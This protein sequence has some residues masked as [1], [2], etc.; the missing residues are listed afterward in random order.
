M[1]FARCHRQLFYKVLLLPVLL[2]SVLGSCAPSNVR[3]QPLAEAP[4]EQGLN[5]DLLYSLLAGEIAGNTGNLEASVKF[6][7]QAAL[8]SEDSR[9]AARATYISLYSKDYE[10][11]LAAL[12]RWDE[13]AP[14]ND[15]VNRMYAVAYLK[16]HEPELAVSYIRKILDAADYTP[17]QK[18]LAVK[19]LL[20]RESN[21]R[22]GLTVLAILNQSDPGNSKMLI[23]Q[24]R[25]AAQLEQYDDSVALLDE[26]L[27]IDDS[28][29]DVHIIKSRILAAQGHGEQA[30][31]IVRKVIADQPG[32]TALRMRFA[33]MLVEERKLD[34]AREQFLILREQTPENTDVLLSLALLHIDTKELDKAVEYLQQ[35]V[36][37]DDQVEVAYYYLGRIA[38]NREQLKLAISYY[39]KVLNGQYMFDSRL[40]VAGLL[41]RLGKNDEALKQLETL[42]EKQTSWPNQVRAYLA[43]GEILR[44]MNRFEEALDMYN[45]VLQ[46]NPDDSDLLYARAMIAEK[47]DRLD[48]TEAD[49]LKVLSTEPENANALNALGYTLADRT[50]RLYEARDYIKRAAELVPDDP[51][52]LDS[53]GW[54]NYRLG[55][56]QEAVKWLGKAYEKLQ[57]AEIAA[58]YGEVLWKLNKQDE[59]RKVWAKAREL[60]ANHPVLLETLQRLKQ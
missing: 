30:L 32:N 34:E 55:E 50:Q 14:D 12:E 25:Y 35:I 10:S 21:T 9:V 45:R 23:L 28:L 44:K 29:S 7:L 2:V 22:D 49:L 4:L 6:Y 5:A 48:I 16:L 57:D 59:A 13:L 1:L 37:L 18:T 47:V 31:E 41:A 60:D 54:V 36:E 52:I 43:R 51:A 17:E 15:D 40:G 8:D 20:Q 53:L 56:M 27:R 33:R 39:I 58:H 19:K 11:A 26:V 38:Q 42:A 46:Q 24:A 3:N